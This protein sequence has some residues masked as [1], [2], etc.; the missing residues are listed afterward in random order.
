MDHTLPTSRRWPEVMHIS[1]S[2]SPGLCG[3]VTSYGENG[4]HSSCVARIS[5]QKNACVLCHPLNKRGMGWRKTWSNMGS[6]SVLIEQKYSRSIQ[7]MYLKKSSGRSDIGFMN[8]TGWRFRHWTKTS[9]ECSTDSEMWLEVHPEAFESD[10]P[11]QN[12]QNQQFAPENG[13]S[14]KETTSSNCTGKTYV[15]PATPREHSMGS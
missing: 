2:C 15:L 6:T 10:Y 4:W 1:V 14:Q 3:C 7:I 9:C 5:N 8:R 13:P 11:P 12:Y